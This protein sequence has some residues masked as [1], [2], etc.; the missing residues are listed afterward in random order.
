MARERKRADAT[1]FDMTP[2]I[3]CTFQLIIFFILTMTMVNQNLKDVMLPTALEAVDEKVD[4]VGVYM[5]HIYNRDLKRDRDTPKPEGWE[6]TT[7]KSRAD[8][9]IT[10]VEQLVAVLE[11]AKADYG[12]FKDGTGGIKLSEL[13][14][15]V[16]GDMRAPSHYFAVILAA[17][18][19][20]R[21]AIHKV[22][23]SI[24]P[25]PD[26]LAEWERA[27]IK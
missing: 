15:L 3:D 7:P 18:S 16:R 26:R 21:V 1:K 24:A 5:L 19:D 9:H 4:E 23:L 11:R 13:T 10:T 14:V 8:Q 27:K 20:R 12:K 22:Q 17:C 25:P 6:I 2:M